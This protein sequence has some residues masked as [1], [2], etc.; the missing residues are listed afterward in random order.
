MENNEPMK[1]AKNI[2]GFLR[3]IK[4]MV[5]CTCNQH[6]P[7]LGALLNDIDQAYIHHSHVDIALK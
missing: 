3:L 4:K 6:W 7:N 2:I 5:T 1:S